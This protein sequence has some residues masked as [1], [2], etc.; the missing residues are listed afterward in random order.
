MNRKYGG[1]VLLLIVWALL[2]TVW[3]FALLRPIPPGAVVAAG[4]P[5]NSFWLGK[6]LH[7][8]VYAVL[9]IGASFLPL[10]PVLRRCVIV[11]LILHGGLTEYLQQFVHRGASWRDV[12]LDTL[13]VAIGVG[14]TWKRWFRTNGDGCLNRNGGRLRGSRQRGT[15]AQEEMEKDG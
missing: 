14:L 4:G 13:G 1:Q 8:S 7:V 2:L 9:A 10:S 12:G 11:A 5:E 6:C 15:P 3:T